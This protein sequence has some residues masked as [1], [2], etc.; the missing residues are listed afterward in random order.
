MGSLDRV[1]AVCESSADRLARCF[2]TPRER[3]TV[4]LNGIEVER[5]APGPGVVHEAMRGRRVVITVGRLTP[6]KGLETL[7]SAAPRVLEATPDAGFLIVGDGPLRKDLERAARG[8]GAGNRVVFA[9]ERRDVHDLM[10]GA[11]VLALPS[12]YEAFPLVV[13]EAMACGLPV[14]ASGVDGV[15]EA[16]VDGETGVLVPPGDADWLAE[17]LI[18][19]LNDP[20]EAEAMGKRGRDRAEAFFSADRM[21]RETQAVYEECLRG[22]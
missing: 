2:G 13:L 17:A 8:T 5:F 21:A 6:Q 12:V 10:R 22:R 15:P 1:V 4:I 3:L 16:V 20:E 18:G 11:K 7:I 9:G 19:L 14:A